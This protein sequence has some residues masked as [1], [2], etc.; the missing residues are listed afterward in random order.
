MRNGNDDVYP[1]GVMIS[2]RWLT[3]SMCFAGLRLLSINV[4][5]HKTLNCMLNGRG[6]DRRNSSGRMSL[7][8][9]VDARVEHRETHT[10]LLLD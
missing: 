3:A 1:R 5:P 8:G 7:K 6:D 9:L 2:E 4:E 10:V